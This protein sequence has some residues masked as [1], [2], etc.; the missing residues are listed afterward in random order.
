MNLN[1]SQTKPNQKKL[2]TVKD[3]RRGLLWGNGTVRDL[4]ER[5]LDGGT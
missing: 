5:D 3:E 2:V 4:D 1:R